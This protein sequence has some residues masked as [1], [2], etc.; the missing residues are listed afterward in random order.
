[1]KLILTVALLCYGLAFA[2]CKFQV[3]NQTRIPVTVMA[4]ISFP[5]PKSATFT[6]SAGDTG[7]QIINSP[8]LCNSIAPGNVGVAS[9]VVVEP[10]INRGWYY[11]P[12]SNIIR[13]SGFSRGSQNYVAGK[14]RAGQGIILNNNNKPDADKF[15]VTIQYD[16]SGTSKQSSS[17]N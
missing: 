15:S 13:A 2:D 16:G 7:Y 12:D 11:I 6:I 10:Q 14:A 8:A 9:V 4:K 3:Y 5:Q 17:L 1:M